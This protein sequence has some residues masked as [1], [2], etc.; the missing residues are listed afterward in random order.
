MGLI[1]GVRD[2]KFRVMFYVGWFCIVHSRGFGWGW[3][4][5]GVCGTSNVVY[6][7]DVEGVCGW[8]WVPFFALEY[9]EF[10]ALL[11]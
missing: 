7:G 1:V 2:F 6:G 4:I 10:S 3:D 8:R 9:V 11:D 5:V